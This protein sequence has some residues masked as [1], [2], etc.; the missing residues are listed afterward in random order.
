[1]AAVDVGVDG[2]APAGRTL[3]TSSCANMN[4]NIPI[5][6]KLY[7]A[8]LWLSLVASS[9]KFTLTIHIVISVF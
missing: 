3:I 6:K 9:S 4:T 1:M 7:I 5:S 8:W 2:S